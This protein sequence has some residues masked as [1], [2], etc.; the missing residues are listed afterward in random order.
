MAGND[1]EIDNSGSW[2]ATVI[3][4]VT[5]P[6]I[7]AGTYELRVVDDSGRPGSTSVTA[8]RRSVTFDPPESRVGSTITVSGTGWIA[9]NSAT[10]AENSDVEVK[11]ESGGG[12][13]SSRATPDSDGNFST[14]IKV[15]LNALFLQA[16]GLR[17]LTNSRVMGREVKRCPTASPALT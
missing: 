16:T 10:G 3:L 9:S 8:P 2:V 1:I 15:P 7:D 17:F 6:L 5:A 13:T 14:T 4:P 11:Y 12:D